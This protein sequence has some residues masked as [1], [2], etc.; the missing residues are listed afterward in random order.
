MSN[1]SNRG[2]GQTGGRENL[3]EPTPQRD[4]IPENGPD[5]A[6][7]TSAA[8]GEEPGT[9]PDRK[10]GQRDDIGLGNANRSPPH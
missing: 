3:R 10:P 8:T 1:K 4:A 9:Q 7:N 6:N 2:G 5:D